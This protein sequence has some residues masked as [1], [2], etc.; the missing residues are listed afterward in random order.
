MLASHDLEIRGAGELLGEEQSGRMQM[1]GFHLYHDLLRRTIEMLKSGQHA[2]LYDNLS[3]E[4]KID[5]GISCIIPEHYLPDAYMR[6]MCYKRIAG[7]KSDEELALIKEEMIDRFGKFEESILHLFASSRLKLFAQKLAVASI[8][9]FDDKAHICFAQNT[10]VPLNK[11]INL[12]EKKPSALSF[13]RTKHTG[14]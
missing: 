4:T 10:S 14:N 3:T 12:L 7:A 1:V 2:M 5:S 8:I 11:I 9:I 6:L 13:K